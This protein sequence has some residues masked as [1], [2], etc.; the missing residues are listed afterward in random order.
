M[1]LRSLLPHL[2]ALTAAA[3]CPTG[4]VAQTAPSP[5]FSQWTWESIGPI[6]SNSSEKGITERTW[7]SGDRIEEILTLGDFQHT[8]LPSFTLNQILAGSGLSG[9]GLLLAEVP[10]VGEQTIESLVQ[11]IPALGS[12]SLDDVSPLY[13]LVATSLGTATASSL[14]QEKLSNLIGESLIASL[15]LSEL[16]L[17]NYSLFSIPHLTETALNQFQGWME[18]ALAAIPGLPSLP[19]DEFLNLT[20]GLLSAA[21]VDMVFG[22]QEAYRTNTVTGSYHVGFEYSCNLES[23]SHV[24]LSDLFV[25]AP[26]Y[27]GKQW[28]GGDSQWVPGGSGCLLGTEPTGRH[29]YGDSF[30]IVLTDTDEGEATAEFSLY[31]RFCV[32]CGCSPYYVGPFPYQILREKETIIIGY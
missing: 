6:Q 28:I 18:E 17:S 19:F 26:V 32:P 7:F 22:S 5:D 8:Q 11:A 14:A 10:L 23:C 25:L 15:P 24:E 30:K 16:N 4:L 29:P 31:F 3:A 13:D 1:N 20:S 27:V 12:F 2:A 21:Q 9:V